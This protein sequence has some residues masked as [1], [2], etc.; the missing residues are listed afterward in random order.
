MELQEEASV[1]HSLM[2][3][4]VDTPMSLANAC[5]VRLSEQYFECRVFTLDSDF[6]H[7]RRNGR[8]VIPLLYP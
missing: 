3:R 1:I 6:E 4:Y 8:Q 7:Y 5:M 2:K